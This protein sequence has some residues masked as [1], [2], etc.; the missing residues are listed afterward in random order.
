[1]VL[2]LRRRR[3]VE[4]EAYEV[5]SGDFRIGDIQR[6]SSTTNEAW[7]WSIGTVYLTGDKKGSPNGGGTT[8]EEAMA[9][10]AAR[11]RI[12]LAT[13]GLREIEPPPGDDPTPR[14]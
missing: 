14:D 8:L 9:N 4:F 1:M 6:L 7:H 2:R 12:W 11:W 3:D 13:A 5:I 10:M